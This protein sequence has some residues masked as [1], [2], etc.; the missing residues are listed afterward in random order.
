MVPAIG[1]LI[2]NYTI[3]MRYLKEIFK[4]IID[5]PLQDLYKDKYLMDI[6]C[7]I[8]IV[9]PNDTPKGPYMEIEDISCMKGNR[10]M[11]QKRTE[12]LELIKYI[13]EK[14]IKSYCEVGVWRGGLFILM[15]ALL[16]RYNKDFER[17][18]VIEPEATRLEFI[19]DYCKLDY[20]HTSEDIISPLGFD[21]CFIDG[22]HSYEWV[23]K[24]W[25]NVGKKSKVVAFHDIKHK[26]VPGVAKCW[27]E[28]SRNL[29]SFEITHPPHEIM[30]IGLVNN[31]GSI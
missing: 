13:R 17:A 12:V 22:D 27:K 9:P 26:P 3:K 2:L 21:L 4:K 14:E 28:I 11:I 16:I 8:G 7:E 19:E 10:L 23:R 25:E 15:T 30:G 18:A 1:N 20:F 29:P 24:D 5:A 6:M 31:E